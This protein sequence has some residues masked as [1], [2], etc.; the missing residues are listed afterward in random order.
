MRTTFCVFLLATLAAVGPARADTL[1]I[2]GLEQAQQTAAK[3]PARGMTM[4]KVASKWGAPA[5]KDAAVGK[6]PIT[7]WEYPDFIV[8]FEYDHVIHAVATHPQG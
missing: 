7:R 1:I 5:V 6:P 3:R 2:E 8:F 4:D